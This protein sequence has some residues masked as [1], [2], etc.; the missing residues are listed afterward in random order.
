MYSLI[1]LFK[2]KEKKIKGNYTLIIFI[3]EKVLKV[4]RSSVKVWI[5]NNNYKIKDYLLEIFFKE[6]VGNGFNLNR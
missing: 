2:K 5:R 6:L 4:F 3:L 1:L